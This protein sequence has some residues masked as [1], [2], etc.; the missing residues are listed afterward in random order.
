MIVTSIVVLFGLGLA[1]S[2]VLSVASVVLRVDEDPRIEAVAEALPGANCGGC[3]YAGCESYAKAVVENPDVPPDLCCAGGASVTVAVAELTGKAAGD[4]APKVA[5]RR[6]DKIGGKV[7]KKFGY[8]G[9][10]SCSAAKLVQNGPDACEYSCL[11]FADCVRACPFDA[12][13]MQNGLV[14]IDPNKCTACGTCVRVC[15]NNILVLIPLGARVMVYCSSKDKGKA[16]MDVCGVG[17][18]SCQKCVK[19]CPADVITMKDNKI[20][21]DHEKCLEYGPSCEEICAEVCPVGI[22][23][24]LKTREQIVAELG[25]QAA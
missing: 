14:E 18:I 1:A 16:V 10:P 23:R 20:H 17:C 12:M 2:V 6:C 11:G 8:Q 15:P 9:V 24:R 19:K 22:M 25:E 13:Y 7:K 21:I 4:G 5:F 3:G